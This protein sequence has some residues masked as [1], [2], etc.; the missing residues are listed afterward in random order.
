LEALRPYF[1]EG[2]GCNEKVRS[3]L[4]A[5]QDF[6]DLNIHL[7]FDTL[8]GFCDLLHFHGFNT[9]SIDDVLGYQLILLRATSAG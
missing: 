2:L 1:P 9:P 8:V 6:S 7:L 3:Q 4:E 5:S